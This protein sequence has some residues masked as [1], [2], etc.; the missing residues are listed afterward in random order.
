MESK[1]SKLTDIVFNKNDN[2]KEEIKI[3]AAD[4][5]KAALVLRALNHKLRQDMLKTIDAHKNMTVSQLFSKLR[6]EQSVVSQHL[7][8]LR[9]AKIVMVSREGKYMHYS[10]NK[11]YLGFIAKLIREF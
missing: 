7:A 8:V 11:E 2:A 3:E 10:I 9:Q 4:L 1:K 5:K 6:V